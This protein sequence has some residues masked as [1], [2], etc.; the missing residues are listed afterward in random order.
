[1]RVY[2]RRCM[3][4]NYVYKKGTEYNAIINNACVVPNNVS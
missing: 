1:M 4:E 3:P 2:L